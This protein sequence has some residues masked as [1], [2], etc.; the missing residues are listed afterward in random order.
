[1][2][3]TAGVKLLVDAMAVEVSVV[4]PVHGRIA[5]MVR[6]KDVGAPEV[7][8]QEALDEVVTGTAALFNL[9]LSNK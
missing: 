7:T 4:G 8:A 2:K 3:V 6:L 1:M 9:E 5:D